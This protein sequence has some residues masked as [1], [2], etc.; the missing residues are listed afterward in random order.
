MIAAGSNASKILVS[1]SAVD[2]G[3]VN[4]IYQRSNCRYS[5]DRRHYYAG[6]SE[7]KVWS[8]AGTGRSLVK[9]RPL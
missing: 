3:Y 4:G 9:F 8:K 6:T 2:E 1:A 5:A 7:I